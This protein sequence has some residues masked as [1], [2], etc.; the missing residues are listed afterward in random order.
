MLQRLH[1]GSRNAPAVPETAQ[2][3][4]KM[5]NREE[6]PVLSIPEYGFLFSIQFR[7]PFSAL[8]R[9]QPV[10]RENFENPGFPGTL[11]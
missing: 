8:E 7:F 2:F 1:N 6:E 3:S 4:T 10:E 11:R 9:R 5:T